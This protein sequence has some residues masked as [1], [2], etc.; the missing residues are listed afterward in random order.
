M[1]GG[2]VRTRRF[3]ALRQLLLC[4]S[5]LGCGEDN[6]PWLIP[7][8][9]EVRAETAEADSSWVAVPLREYGS[10]SGEISFGAPV[11]ATV[12][13]D[14]SLVVADLYACTLTVIARPDGRLRQK[15]GRCGDGPGEFRM[16]R[17]ID[18]FA[19]SLFVYDQGHGAVV[20]LDETGHETRRVPLEIVGGRGV[21]L[22]HLAVLDDSTLVIATE[23]VDHAGV[24]LVDSRTGAFRRSLVEAPPIAVRSDGW[25]RHMAACV[26]PNGRSPT[27]VATSE[28]ALEGVGLVS[29]TGEERF[30]FL[31]SLDLPPTL[32][33]G[34]AWVQGPARI[35]VACG[36]SLALFR[37]VTVD[38]DDFT[39]SMADIRASSVIL[40]AR[41]YD[42]ALLMRRSIMDT[43]PVLRAPMGAFRGDT[44]FL[45]ADRVRPYPVVSEIV[46]RPR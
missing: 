46:L 40:E 31:T 22:S 9:S 7:G 34:G 43:S 19:G 20:V 37:A 26:E 4:F 29:D 45:L 15:L 6:H 30:H 44:V 16:I 18:A 24:A 35:D 42:G 2:Y 25:I 36:R 17:I 12:L 32:A 27:I 33:S 21:T 5:V 14:G 3:H 1:R 10:L 8:L 38:P 28:W 23:S 39:G 13:A 41:A 11:D